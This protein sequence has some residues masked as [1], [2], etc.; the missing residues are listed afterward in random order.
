MRK[1]A[2]HEKKKKKKT[3]EK[4]NIES[5]NENM[6]KIQQADCA[7][8][9]VL[10]GCMLVKWHEALVILKRTFARLEQQ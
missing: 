10:V 5:K 8:V 2:K 9:V 4:K 3:K 6:K 1:D 7:N